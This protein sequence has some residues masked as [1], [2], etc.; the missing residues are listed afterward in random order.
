[1]KIHNLQGGYARWSATILSHENTVLGT[2]S[3]SDK[4]APEFM[5]RLHS[6]EL[7]ARI[8]QGDFFVGG[9]AIFYNG[10]RIANWIGKLGIF[11][12]TNMR[13]MT[14]MQL[15]NDDWVRRF[16]WAYRHGLSWRRA[17]QYA[18]W[19]YLLIG[20]NFALASVI[21]PNGGWLLGAASDPFNEEDDKIV[22]NLPS[23][24][25]LMIL[26][27]IL[28]RLCSVSMLSSHSVGWGNACPNIPSSVKIQKGELSYLTLD[29][30][31]ICPGNRR[32]YWIGEFM[33]TGHPICW[34][35]II[36]SVM[37]CVLCPGKGA[38]VVGMATALG[39]VGFLMLNRIHFSHSIKE[40]VYTPTVAANSPNEEL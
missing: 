13:R 16:K 12:I 21:N 3:Y 7:R 17:R 25:Q 35:I 38:L 31:K 18:S 40:M 36:A 8:T 5:V 29:P 23:Q 37:V 32:S 15:L 22:R 39:A 14:I 6:N 27:I 2:A 26:F 10:E 24:E 19:G 4:P 1:M 33:A 9:G 30:D 28:R 20:K 11:T 34:L